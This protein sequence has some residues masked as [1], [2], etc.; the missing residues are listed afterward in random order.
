ME[1]M[2]TII[3]TF[4]RVEETTMTATINA[5]VAI[6]IIIGHRLLV[7]VFPMGKKWVNRAL[8]N[9]LQSRVIICL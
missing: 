9:S 8:N 1:P 4:I 6:P 2:Y 3:P 7:I 5:H